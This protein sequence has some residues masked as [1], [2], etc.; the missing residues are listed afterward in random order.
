[1]SPKQ[2][3]EPK[4][5]LVR[6]LTIPNKV[7]FKKG[8]WPAPA[9]GED[10][11]QEI[12]QVVPDDSLSLEEILIRFTRGEA[13]PVGHDVQDGED[14]DNPL[15]VDLEK[16]RNSDLV[17]KEEFIEKLKEVQRKYDAQ[18]KE[19]A[20]VEEKKRQEE[21]ARKDAKRI[22]LAARKLAK[23]SPEKLA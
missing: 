23:E 12:D 10:Y 13:L 14:S 11:S 18:E 17:D 21:F 7:S 3:E 8:A 5:N 19:K 1:M 15:N 20:A 2:K 16:L 9:P 22:R 6:P 4:L